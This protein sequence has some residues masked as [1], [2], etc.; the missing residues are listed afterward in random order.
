MY[1]GKILS[2]SFLQGIITEILFFFLYLGKKKLN[3]FI[4][5]ARFYFFFLS[6]FI[7]T[8]IFFLIGKPFHLFYFKVLANF[9]GWM[10]M[11]AVSIGNHQVHFSVFKDI[12]YKILN[13]FDIF[14]YKIY[15]S[16]K[17]LFTYIVINILTALWLYYKKK[18]E[19]KILKLLFRSFVIFFYYVLFS[20]LELIKIIFYTQL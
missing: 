9:P 10:T 15:F 5:G 6:G 4:L 7:L 19:E 13:Q 8:I 2:L 20:H 11:F 1:N 16:D 17:I 18:L 14:F 3:S 12:F